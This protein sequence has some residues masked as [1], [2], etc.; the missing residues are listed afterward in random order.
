[1]TPFGD[2]IYLSKSLAPCSFRIYMAIG[3]YLHNPKRLYGFFFQNYR[4][5]CLLSAP[6]VGRRPLVTPFGNEIYLSKSL[7]PCSFRIYMVIGV[8]LQNPRRSSITNGQ[9]DRQKLQLYNI[10]AEIP[11]RCCG[12]PS[13]GRCLMEIKYTYPSTLCHVVSEYIYCYKGLSQKS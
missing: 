2:E 4:I 3:V 10:L 5:D 7:A 11:A 8:Y 12:S 6:S 13:G 1:M 9:T